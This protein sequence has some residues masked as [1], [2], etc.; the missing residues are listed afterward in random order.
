MLAKKHF[1]TIHTAVSY[2]YS[3]TAPEIV[4]YHFTILRMSHTVVIVSS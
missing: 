1:V 4:Y 3:T 2:M